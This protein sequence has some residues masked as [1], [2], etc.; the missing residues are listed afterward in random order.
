MLR[1]A[2]GPRFH[3]R[4]DVIA[5]TYKRPLIPRGKISGNLRKLYYAQE[6]PRVLL[7]FIPL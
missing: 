4:P 2:P 3:P 5:H 1:N 6:N 7:F